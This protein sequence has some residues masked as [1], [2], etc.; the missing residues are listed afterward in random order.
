MFERRRHHETGEVYHVLRDFSP[1]PRFPPREKHGVHGRPHISALLFADRVELERGWC[2]ISGHMEVYEERTE[3]TLRRGDEGWPGSV[4]AAVADWFG[5]AAGA[6][7]VRLLAD[8]AAFADD[9]ARP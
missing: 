4:E 7:A 1:P 9:D 8:P 2:Y 5:A 6:E 3:A